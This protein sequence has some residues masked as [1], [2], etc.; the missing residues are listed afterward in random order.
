M[1]FY[2]FQTFFI[3]G[4]GFHFLE[5]FALL[6]QPRFIVGI[7]D[8]NALFKIS[9]N[10]GI[11][12]IGSKTAGIATVEKDIAVEG[13]YLHNFIAFAVDVW[14]HFKAVEFA[15][16]RAW[17]LSY[18]NRIFFHDK[19]SLNFNK[20]SIRSV[21]ILYEIYYGLGYLRL[22]VLNKWRRSAPPDKQPQSKLHKQRKSMRR[23]KSGFALTRLQTP[24]YC[25][26]ARKI[27]YEPFLFGVFSASIR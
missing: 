1:Q 23:R 6:I 2:A 26:V 24:D 14:L 5:I 16:F 10:H 3:T 19:F 27:D 15:T 9:I 12:D 25:S 4:I 18:N 7:K 13:M 22:L 17:L 21:V 11:C 20:N 8:I